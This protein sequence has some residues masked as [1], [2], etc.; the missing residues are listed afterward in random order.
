MPA[1]PKGRFW[2]MERKLVAMAACHHRTKRSPLVR[3]SV[4]YLLRAAQRIG[5]FGVR[6][7]FVTVSY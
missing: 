7:A 5:I 3:A 1:G 6:M 4:A 2:P